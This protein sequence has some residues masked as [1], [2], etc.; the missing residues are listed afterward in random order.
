MTGFY[1]KRKTGLKWVNSGKDDIIYFFIAESLIFRTKVSVRPKDS[2]VNSFC[3]K[4]YPLSG[5]Y[6]GF[7]CNF[8][9]LQMPY[10]G[11]QV[12]IS[13][14][15]TQPILVYKLPLQLGPRGSQSAI[16]HLK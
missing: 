7:E 4:R 1:M 2:L 13:A 9:F 6:L 3:L 11:R 12:T 10:F 16:E 5:P 8:R 14:L 15:S